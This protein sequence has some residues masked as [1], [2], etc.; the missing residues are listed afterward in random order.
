MSDLYTGMQ[1]DTSGEERRFTT[2]CGAVWQ[3]VDLHLHSPG[4]ESFRCPDG[5][6]PLNDSHRRKVVEAYVYRLI[7]ASIK[8]ASI[9]DYNGIR[10]EWFSPIRDLAEKQ[11]ITLLPGVEVSFEYPK[12]GLHVLAIFRE[13]EDPKSINAFLQAEDLDSASPLFWSDRRHR[14]IRARD[15]PVL[16]LR[17]LRD[18][19]HCLI[20][21]SHPNGDSGFLKSMQMKDAVDFLSDLRPDAIEHLG[22][23]DLARLKN[24]N[25]R[26][27]PWLDRMARVEFSDPK[28]MEDI[29]SKQQ[30]NGVARATYLKLS[31]TGIE[32]LRL[33]LHDP[34]TRLSVGGIPAPVHAKIESMVVSGEF[35]KKFSV[36]W[37]DDLNVII[38][39]RGVGKSA[40]LETLRY[41]LDMESYSDKAYRQALV[42]YA[43]GSG[44]KVEVQLERTVGE[45]KTRQ[46]RITRVLGEDPVVTEVGSAEPVAI[47]PS[48]LLG[49]A[50]GPI[51]FGQREIYAISASE[52]YRL[53]LLD[54]LIGEEARKRANAVREGVD[55][56]RSNARAILDAR[57]RLD[58]REDYRQRLKGIEHEILVYEKH[59]AADK[60]AEGVKLRGDGQRLKTA[61]SAVKRSR[62]VWADWQEGLLTPL[63]TAQRDLL[64]GQSLQKS[65]LADSAR[66]IGELATA[67]RDLESRGTAL[68][69]KADKELEA[70][71]T[72]WRE[73]ITPL[74]DQLN[75]IKQEAQTD[76]LDP[77]RLL[78]LAQ[79]KAAL[80][81]LIE[82]LDRQERHV[83]DLLDKRRI[84]L[85]QVRERRHEEHAL[86]RERAESIARLL[87]GRVRLSIEF[88]GQKEDYKSRLAT[89]LKGSGVSQEAI[90]NLTTPEAVDGISLA[91]AARAGG[92]EIQDRFGL[93]QAMASRVAKWFTDDESRLY[94]LE[95]LIPPDAVRV[96]L[97]VDNEY[98]PLAR[99]SVGQRATA[100]LL[101]LF[102]LE[103][104]VLVLDQPEDDL[105]NR[106]VYEDIVQILRS[107]KGLGDPGKRRQII[108]VTHNANIPVIGDAELVLALEV[109]DGHAGIIGRASID[110]PR[111]RELIKTIME[112]GEEAFLRRAEK[113]G[114][115]QPAS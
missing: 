3:R 79:E 80:G 106:F 93:T 33:A 25:S 75:R 40:L 111:T 16:V 39:G 101:L 115:L 50:G 26:P 11:G 94:E 41:A 45:G 27:L 51:I 86:R 92:E 60:L 15:N 38:G 29:G 78:N 13:S 59:G 58:K 76:S 36:A 22:D 103:G 46:Y 12:Y 64:R 65:I 95:T 20:I 56:L 91:E 9:T 24:A 32:A 55:L 83:K 85:Q 54:E 100:I 104:R 57:A 84:L 66:V 97:K 6:D 82:E 14:D 68:F 30:A 42:Q 37:N 110:D 89:L 107:Q 112:G 69:D 87:E 17:R 44:G 61:Q 88:K 72:R 21:P 77:D 108:A 23:K 62:Q 63:D 47:P 28:S 99:L 31:A 90:E 7:K 71:A 35:L 43:L 18:R 102:A 1:A 96:E 81:P 48:D 10:T 5:A 109:Q 53:A 34:A 8:V 4:V 113:Y 49:P 52:E 114:G 98:R 74:T 67:L 19:F 105:D 73:A 2:S 70:S